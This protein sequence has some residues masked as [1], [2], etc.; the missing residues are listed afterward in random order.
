MIF[1]ILVAVLGKSSLCFSSWSS[2]RSISI[3][4][5]GA[6]APEI[7]GSDMSEAADRR[8]DDK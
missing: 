2:R 5:L 1:L 3:D 6:I 8:H 7:I 4:E